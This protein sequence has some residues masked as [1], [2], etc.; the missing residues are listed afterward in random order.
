MDDDEA[1]GRGQAFQRRLVRRQQLAGRRQI[2]A[3]G[4]PLASALQPGVGKGGPQPLRVTPELL[5]PLERLGGKWVLVVDVLAADRRE[6]LRVLS[7]PRRLPAVDQ[8][9]GVQTGIPSC[10]LEASA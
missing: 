1:V 5:C 4:Q 2:V 8:L 3:V 7:G 9:V 6:R 10:G